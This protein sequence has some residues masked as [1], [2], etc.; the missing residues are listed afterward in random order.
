[1]Y[2]LHKV[3]LILYKYLNVALVHPIKSRYI[4]TKKL[5]N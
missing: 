2:F 3:M 1:M 5:N 4:I